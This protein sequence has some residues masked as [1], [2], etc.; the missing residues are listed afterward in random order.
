MSGSDEE[1]DRRAWLA[2]LGMSGAA[3]GATTVGFTKYFLDNRKENPDSIRYDPSDTYECDPEG[4]TCIP[5]TD[6]DVIDSWEESIPG[7]CSLDAD[8]RHWLVSQVDSYDELD[9]DDFFDYVGREVR[10]EDSG[11]ELRMTVDPDYNGKFGAE[12]EYIVEE[13]N[14]YNIPDA[15]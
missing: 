3:V 15:C 4:T 12:T 10:L 7:G 11:T 9:G 8:E 1:I 2:L 14:G 6:G 13:G 5:D